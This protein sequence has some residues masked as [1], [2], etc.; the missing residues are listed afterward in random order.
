MILVALTRQVW[1]Y[2]D[3]FH[4]WLWLE[5]PLVTW[6][7][8][9]TSPNKLLFCLRSTIAK[10]PAPLLID[11]ITI[12]VCRG[13]FHGVY[14]QPSFAVFFSQC[15]RSPQDFKEKFSADPKFCC[16]NSHPSWS[17][18]VRPTG[19]VTS[20]QNKRLIAFMKRFIVCCIETASLHPI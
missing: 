14:Q 18:K 2:D 16:R 19:S 10:L 15:Q 11:E 13:F 9:S 1:S 7:C 8:A 12:F 5:S 20:D 4:L 17:G 3:S 6:T